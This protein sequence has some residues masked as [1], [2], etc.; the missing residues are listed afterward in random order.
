MI[1]KTSPWIIAA[2][3]GCVVGCQPAGYQMPDAVKLTGSLSQDGEILTV[4][5]MENGTGMIVVG[6][7]PIVDDKPLE[8]VTTAMVN[9]EGHFEIP[10]GIEPGEYLITVRQWQ[11][12]LENDLL[13]G[14]FGPTKSKIRRTIDDDTELTIDLA[15]PDG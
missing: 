10:Q 2:I 1:Q 8:E 15:Q 9:Q 13:Q 6:F 5:G 7:H 3:V 11:P 4:E 12:Y 14:E